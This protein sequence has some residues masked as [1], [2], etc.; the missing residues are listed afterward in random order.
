MEQAGN[1]KTKYHPIQIR[2]SIPISISLRMWAEEE[3]GVSP[4]G[5]AINN[6][7]EW[8]GLGG[9]PNLLR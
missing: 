6:R 3:P 2:A 9:P 1:E 8:N 5:I 4:A 7:M